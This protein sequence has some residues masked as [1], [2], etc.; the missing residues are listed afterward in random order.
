LGHHQLKRDA[1][2]K[3]N[4]AEAKAIRRISEPISD[5]DWIELPETTEEEYHAALKRLKESGYN[6]NVPIKN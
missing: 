6:V 2:L 4:S 5:E 1:W 3:E